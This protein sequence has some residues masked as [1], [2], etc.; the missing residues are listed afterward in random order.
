M[1]SLLRSVGRGSQASTLFLLSS[2]LRLLIYSPAR[3]L[4]S[5]ITAVIC[6]ETSKVSLLWKA[7]PSGR[8]GRKER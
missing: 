7:L 1:E 6:W 5:Q 3:P 8:S 4:Y 2:K